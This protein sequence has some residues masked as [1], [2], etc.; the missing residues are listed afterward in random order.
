ME[1]PA[2]S[3]RGIIESPADWEAGNAETRVART[4]Y[5]RTSP[6]AVVAPHAEDEAN[7]DLGN[8]GRDVEDKA[9]AADQGR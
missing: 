1:S 6:P 5:T 8:L 2:D 4:D 9:K 7:S 3:Y